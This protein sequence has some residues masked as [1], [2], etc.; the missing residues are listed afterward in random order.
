MALK[1]Y[2]NPRC[3]KSRETLKIINDAGIK[4]TVVLYL[5]NAPA[6]EE[7]LDVAKQLGTP[8][9]ALLRRGEKEFKDAKDVPDLDDD[10]AVARWLSAHPIVLQRPIVIDTDL[11]RA[12]LGR[13]PENAKELLGPVHTKLKAP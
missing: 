12:V 13:P 5:K 3:S 4:P 10:A 7:L 9:S 11:G 8:I 6:A 2:H 1:I